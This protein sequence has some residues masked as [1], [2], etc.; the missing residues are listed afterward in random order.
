VLFR[1]YGYVYSTNI[2]V[3]VKPDM[4]V[5]LRSVAAVPRPEDDA[6]ASLFGKPR[7]VVPATPATATGR[8][9]TAASG[10]TAPGAGASGAT[11]AAGTGAPAVAGGASAYKEWMARLEEFNKTRPPAESPEL[12]AWKAKRQEFLAEGES[13]RKQ[14]AAAAAP[15]ATPPSPEGR[16]RRGVERTP[17]E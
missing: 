5:E 8:P 1:S 3:M 14:Q 6:A 2:T 15:P 9:G 11:S 7:A 12:A 17:N 16:R 10:T 4:K 13:L